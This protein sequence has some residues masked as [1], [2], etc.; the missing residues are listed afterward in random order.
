[1][2]FLLLQKWFN[3]TNT[4]HLII[5]KFLKG[6]YFLPLCFVIIMHVLIIIIDRRTQDCRQDLFGVCLGVRLSVCP[7]VHQSVYLATFNIFS[8]KRQTP[9][10][11]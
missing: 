3:L 9:L 7:S 11:L 4:T 1:M 8:N 6:S 2:Y 10:H 5:G